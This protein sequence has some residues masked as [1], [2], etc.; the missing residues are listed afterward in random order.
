MKSLKTVDD[1]MCSL[2]NRDF[3][4]HARGKKC[5]LFDTKWEGIDQEIEAEENSS[6]SHKIAQSVHLLPLYSHDVCGH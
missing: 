5:S 3:I 1:F 6:A 4:G 2:V